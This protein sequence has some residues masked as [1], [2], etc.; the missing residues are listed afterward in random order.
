MPVSSPAD[1]VRRL[2]AAR[3]RGDLR[4]VLDL[5][6]P[7]VVATSAVRASF[8]GDRTGDQ[9]TEVD[10]HHLVADGD[11]VTVRGRI[12]VFR[13]GGLV[14]SP[15]CWR[16]VVRAGRVLRID[17]LPGSAPRVAA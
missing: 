17:P 8:A 9:R 3:E 5:L 13:G 12:R 10:A 7:D 6:H 4:G 15:A 2:F 11:V 14:D 1:T 16:F